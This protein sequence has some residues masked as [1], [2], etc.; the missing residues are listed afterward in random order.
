MYIP[1]SHL[2][3]VVRELLSADLVGSIES[4]E[5]GF[6]FEIDGDA[7]AADA[8]AIDNPNADVFTTIMEIDGVTFHIEATGDLQ[9][10][11]SFTIIDANQINGVPT[12]VSYDSTEI[13]MTQLDQIVDNNDEK[14]FSPGDDVESAFIA[15]V[16]SNLP[17]ASWKALPSKSQPDG[18][19]WTEVSEVRKNAHPYLVDSNNNKLIL[20]AKDE[21]SERYYAAKISWRI[22]SRLSRRHTSQHCSRQFSTTPF[23]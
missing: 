8:L 14:T 17:V 1:D 21:T 19:V 3:S 5:T 6:E 11:D 10:G 2:Q 12:E 18:H 4:N 7:D 22:A 13:S 20:V 23:R 16:E 15:E 9:P